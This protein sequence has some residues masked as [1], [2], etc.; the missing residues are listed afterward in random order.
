VEQFLLG[1]VAQF[2]SGCIICFLQ[3]MFILH[4]FSELIIFSFFGFFVLGLGL[5]LIVEGGIRKA[6][7]APS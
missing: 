3:F 6:K 2:S 4:R 7:Q 5:L 1:L